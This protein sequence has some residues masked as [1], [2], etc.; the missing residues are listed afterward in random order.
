MSSINVVVLSGRLGR[1]PEQRQT[2]NG[3]EVSEFSLAVDRRKKDEEPMWY[4]V[5][6]YGNQA[7]FA[8]QYLEKGRQVVVRGR[9]DQRRYEDRDGINREAITIVAEEIQAVG[10]RQEQEQGAQPAKGKAAADPQRQQASQRP[11]EDDFDPFEDE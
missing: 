4:R 2:T 8:N 6:A 9:L 1:D 11:D 7:A 5:T 3:T 10:S